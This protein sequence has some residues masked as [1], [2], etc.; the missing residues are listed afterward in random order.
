MSLLDLDIPDDVR[1]ALRHLSFDDLRK[2]TVAASFETGEYIGIGFIE[3]GVLTKPCE[4]DKVEAFNV[5]DNYLR[6]EYDAIYGLRK[7]VGMT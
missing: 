7:Y 6:Q 3:H 2:L 5:I 1:D 4:P